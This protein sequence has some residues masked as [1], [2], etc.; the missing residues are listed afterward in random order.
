MAILAIARINDRGADAGL[1]AEQFLFQGRFET[2]DSRCANVFRA[3][4]Y[5]VIND[6][7]L[8]IGA[9]D[10]G[11]QASALRQLV[12]PLQF[13]ALGVFRLEVGVAEA[14]VIQVAEVGRSETFAIGEQQVIVRVERQGKGAAP[15]VLAAI[16]L[17]LVA[18]QTQLGGE[19]V[20]AKAVLNEGCP[21]PAAVFGKSRRAGIEPVFVPVSAEDQAVVFVQAQ[22]VLPVQRVPVGIEYVSFV[23]E[24]VALEVAVLA[25]PQ[26]YSRRPVIIDV[27]I[28]IAADCLLYTSDAADE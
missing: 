14:G 9:E 3:L 27:R 16:L 13:I 6:C 19:T 1:P 22:I 2:V 8:D 23:T 26:L 28:E 17:V 25:M 24:F 10:R 11:L 7:V 18:A 12:T 15:G 20:T 4:G 21:V 5:A